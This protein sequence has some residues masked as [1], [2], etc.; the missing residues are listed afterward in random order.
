MKHKLVR[1]ALSMNPGR[2]DADRRNPPASTI[3]GNHDPFCMQG[4]VKSRSYRGVMGEPGRPRPINRH[5]TPKAAGYWGPRRSV[6][7]LWLRPKAKPER[8]LGPGATVGILGTGVP[9]LACLRPA[10]W[11]RQQVCTAHFHQ[12]GTQDPREGPSLARRTTRDIRSEERRV[13]KECR[14]RWSPYH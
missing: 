12:Q 7:D 2:N 9:R 3:T 13:G 5:A 1:R 8:A 4:L 10:A 11:L 14:S 6:L